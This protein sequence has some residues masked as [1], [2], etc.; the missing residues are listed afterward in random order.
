MFDLSNYRDYDKWLSAFTEASARFD[1]LETA[2]TEVRHLCEGGGVS[3]AQ[4]LEMLK[5]QG[6]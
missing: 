2:V 3:N 1:T 5:R 6:V 4:I